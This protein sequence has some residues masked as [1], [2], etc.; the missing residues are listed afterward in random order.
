MK[1]FRLFSSLAAAGAL[2]ACG[3]SAGTTQEFRAAA[4]TS[5]KLA[6]SQND[7]DSPQG[8]DASDSSASAQAVAAATSECHP[9]LFVRTHEIIGRV[10][11]HFAKHLHH[12]EDLIEDNPLA[13][14]ETRTW[15]KVRDGVDRKFTMTRTA[16]LDGSV[17]SNNRSMRTRH[18]RFRA[19]PRERARQR[20]ALVRQGDVGLHHAH[21][22]RRRGERRRSR[23]AGGEQGHGHVRLHRARFRQDV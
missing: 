4:P 11:R 7:G 8:A 17:R 5:E 9:H 20:F 10:N 21:R 13:N 12:V 15:E 6:I 22:A 18:F 14:G 3:G 23:P 1:V 16:N 19:R 2:A